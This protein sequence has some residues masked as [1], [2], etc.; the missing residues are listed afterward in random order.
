[1]PFVTSSFSLLVVMPGGTSSVLVATN[2]LGGDGTGF[3]QRADPSVFLVAPE[4][5]AN[6]TEPLETLGSLEST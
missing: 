4:R 2:A 3:G 1:M 6:G 5:V